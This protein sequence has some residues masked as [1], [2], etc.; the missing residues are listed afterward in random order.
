[1]GM[2][3]KEATEGTLGRFPMDS[4]QLLMFWAFVLPFLL[5]ACDFLP[6]MGFVLVTCFGREKW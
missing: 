3:K 5:V 2:A 6:P 1:M 4:L